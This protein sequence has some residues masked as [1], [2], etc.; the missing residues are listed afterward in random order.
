MKEG[1]YGK[2]PAKRKNQSERSDFLKNTLLLL[3][4]FYFYLWLCQF[5]TLPFPLSV[6]AFNISFHEAVKALTTFPGSYLYLEVERGPWER[7][8]ERPIMIGN[9]SIQSSCSGAVRTVLMPHIELKRLLRP[10][11]LQR[12]KKV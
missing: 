11:M 10:K 1:P 3:F 5:Q 6:R 2:T 8:C 12:K 4:P 7:G 9:W